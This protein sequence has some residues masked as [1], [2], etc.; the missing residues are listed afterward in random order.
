MGQSCLSSPVLA[1]CY[2]KLQ[3]SVDDVHRKCN[4]SSLAIRGMHV[5]WIILSTKLDSG[6]H[7]ILSIFTWDES[8]SHEAADSSPT[9]ELLI[10][11]SSPCY[12]EQLYI[13]NLRNIKSKS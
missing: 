9:Q 13:F 12:N 1:T 10:H 3:P 11:I 7:I 6:T 4:L 8:H 5:F 2:Y